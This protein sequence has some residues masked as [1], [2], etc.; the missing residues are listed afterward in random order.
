M[1][2]VAFFVLVFIFHSSQAQNIRDIT[3]WSLKLEATDATTYEVIASVQIKSGWYIYSLFLAPD[4]GPIPTSFQY[5]NGIRQIAKREAGNKHEVYDP[6]FEMHL[7]KFS[8][9]AEFTSRIRVPAGVREVEGSYIFMVCD[10]T[11][12]LPPVEQPFTLPIP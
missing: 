12:C 11:K 6:I 2:Y 3:K 10:D 8:E 4:E 5:K 9:T 7:A 1:K